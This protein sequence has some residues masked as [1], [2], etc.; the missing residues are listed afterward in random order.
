[1]KKY[2]ITLFIF[3]SLIIAFAVNQYK[4]YHIERELE[5]TTDKYTRAYYTVNDHKKQLAYIMFTGLKQ[6][7]KLDEI[8]YTAS[9]D[10]ELEKLVLRK[11]LYNEL[12]PR[13]KKLKSLGVKLFQIYLAD[14]KSFLRMH[15]PEVYGDDLAK[16]RQS[17]AYISDTHLPLHTFEEGVYYYGFRSVFPIFYKDK[18]VGAMEISF[19]GSSIT[20]TIMKEYY[21]LSN[22]FIKRTKFNS[23]RIEEKDAL[24][25]ISH[26]DGYYYDKE[27]LAEIKKVARKDIAKLIPSSRITAKIKEIGKGKVPQS[28]YDE[29][30]NAIFTIIPILHTITNENAAFLTIRSKSTSIFFSKVY[31]LTICI[32]CILLVSIVLFL[33][34]NI[35]EKKAYF[36]K[37]QERYKNIL[38]LASDGVYILN[39]NAELIECS[40]AALNML[41]YTKEE[42]YKMSIF[43]WSPS[44][45]EQKHTEILNKLKTGMVSFETQHQR[46]DRSLF[47][48]QINAKLIHYHNEN[49]I[50]AS[51]RDITKE[52]EFEKK[53]ESE[54]D[55]AFS[56][57][58]NSSMVL[59]S[60][61][62]ELEFVNK[63]LLEFFSCTDIVEFKD[64]YK[65]ICHE[66][67]R[68]DRYF[69]LGKVKNEKRWIEEL[70]QIVEKERVVSIIS[71][72]TGERKIFSIYVIKHG[73]NSYLLN[74]TDISG[75]M[76]QQHILENK[77]IH[78]KLTNAYN[79]EYFDIIHETIIDNNK[80]IYKKT[81]I[82]MV[83]IDDFKEVNDN[84]G[85]DIGDE[86]LIDLVRIIKNNFRDDDILIRW[87]GEEFVIIL[88][89]KNEKDF[90]RIL[91]SYRKIIEKHVF[92]KN[93]KITCS[94]GGAIYH[95]NENIT[96]TIKK[97]DIKLY[98]SKRNGK[99]QV[100]IEN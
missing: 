7:G 21:V 62:E 69:H 47:Y 39:L 94:F 43:D 76:L 46:K 6:I 50:Y 32:L 54:R 90:F 71:K 14:G 97:A 60:D 5:N 82:T 19:G 51:A 57:V 64:K 17:I 55:F 77:I 40:Q 100:T 67:I 2:F 28:I 25:K 45:N 38:E 27:V 36:K 73:E 80:K 58:N 79:R 56:I 88:A 74:F 15:K 72:K 22:F 34:Y 44:F 89:I 31:I 59:L 87:G 1:M 53:I 70:L 23:A 12:S 48:V 42:L 95:D 24:Y 41:G 92:I 96:A 99:N 66:F 49:Y 91:E 65:C 8:L 37:E 3:L 83:D 81:A 52:K 30:I 29:N 86:V 20:S 75:Q 93:L 16:L 33:I 13:Y 11:Q 4:I 35:L 84:H 9:N 61:G 26:H 78:D 68:D 10:N 18:Y 98:E 63:S 85:H